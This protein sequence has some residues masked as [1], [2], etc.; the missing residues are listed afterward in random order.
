MTVETAR[1]AL[2]LGS[3]LSPGSC[4]V[5]L[6]GGEP[7][8]EKALIG[9]V[10]REAREMERRRAGRFHFKVTTNGL[11]LD[12]RFL[13]L[14]IRE[15]VLVA[16]SFDG[17]RDAHDA[18]RRLPDGSPT[19][20][21][22][23]GRLRALLEA[24][25][26]SSVLVVASPDTARLLSESV[27]SLLDLGAR[28]LIVS[29]DYSAGW[30]EEAFADLE[31]EYRRLGGLYLRWTRAGRKFYLSPFEVKLSSHIQGSGYRKDRCELARRQV[32]VAPDGSLYPCVQ[33]TRAGPGSEWRIGHVE[34]G[35]DED[36]RR[37][38]H[39]RSEAEKEPCRRC[40]IEPRCNNSCGCLNWQATGSVERVSPVLCRHERTI[41]PIADAVGRRLWRR[42]DPHFI[43]KHYNAAYPV[44]SLI[45]DWTGGDR[46]ADSG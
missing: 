1:R 33:F 45:E 28:Y 24:R 26:Y 3:R 12:E 44:L 29:L 15:D 39:D 20:D 42:R 30:T 25:P 36:R 11:L 6:F 9:E 31:R 38:A 7:L 21:L 23:L 19:H 4:G 37:R 18:H 8:L 40:A 27:S 5:V 16:M 46:P 41:L 22:L 10:L 17:V 32:S 35:I 13:E 43:Q 2:E 34:T 14:A